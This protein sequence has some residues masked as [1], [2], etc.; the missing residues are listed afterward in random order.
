VECQKKSLTLFFK[1]PFTLSLTFRGWNSHLAPI[2][3]LNHQ[4]RVSD[5]KHQSCIAFGA[6]LRIFGNSNWTI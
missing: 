3:T 1:P 6:K 2:S 4:F 5:Q